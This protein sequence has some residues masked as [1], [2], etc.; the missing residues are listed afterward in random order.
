M[1]SIPVTHCVVEDYFGWFYGFGE[2]QDQDEL[3]GEAVSSYIEHM[4][5]VG[6]PPAYRGKKDLR[7]GLF[8]TQCSKSFY[9]E[10]KEGNIVH[11]DE[12]YTVFNA[13]KNRYILCLPEEVK[14]IRKGR[15]RLVFI[16]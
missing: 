3:L 12:S 11:G 5:E 9:K 2:I 1:R 8:V 10:V 13:L 7:D 16:D 4:T 14:M 15:G 6:H